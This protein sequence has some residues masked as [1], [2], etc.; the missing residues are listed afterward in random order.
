MFLFAS[1]P[2]FVPVVLPYVNYQGL[3]SVSSNMSAD[4]QVQLFFSNITP[5]V[6]PDFLELQSMEPNYL[7]IFDLHG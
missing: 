3:Q 4:I 5:Q 1:C 2:E 7:Q 6:H